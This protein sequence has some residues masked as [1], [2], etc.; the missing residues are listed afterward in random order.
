MDPWV[1]GM[2]QTHCAQFENP[3]QIFFL[4]EIFFFLLTELEIIVCD[5]RISLCNFYQEHL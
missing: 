1:S 3:L 5:I 2:L 4:L